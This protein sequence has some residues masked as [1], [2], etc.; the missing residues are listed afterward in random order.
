M[1][2]SDARLSKV[3]RRLLDELLAFRAALPA[4]P[5]P[6][7]GR[8]T[9]VRLAGKRHGRRVQ[10]AAVALALLAA[11]SVI[12]GHELSSSVTFAATPKPLVY[13]ALALNALSGRQE[14]RG[15]A[16]AAGRQ[17]D[18]AI[19]HPRYAYTKTMGWYLAT[20]VDGQATTSAVIPSTTQ[21]WA[22]PNGSTHVHR[23]FINRADGSRSIEDFTYAKGPVPVQLSTDQVVLARQL[24]LGHPLGNGPVEK[25]MA[26]T[27]LALRQPIP[28]GAE[29]AILRFLAR[30]RALINRG[31][32]TDRAGRRG[33]GVALDSNYSGLLTRYTWI[34]DPH[35]GALLGNEETLLDPGKLHVRKGS[36]ISYTTYLSSGWSSSAS[37]PPPGRN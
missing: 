35:T 33:V 19:T 26:L 37:S 32:V 16:A 10:N 28:P 14:L 11:A 15:L 1:S 31:S 23:V 36:V 25:F 29:S 4:D 8:L 20:R 24:A 22:A 21:S 17:P 18:S 27:D 34:F 30:T 5:P 12:V 6:K 2:Y 9:R 3:E 13:H 7:V